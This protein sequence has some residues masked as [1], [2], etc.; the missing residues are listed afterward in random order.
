MASKTV[1]TLPV[2][3]LT[4]TSRP[5]SPFNSGAGLQQTITG[6]NAPGAPGGLFISLKG[7][8]GK[9][10]EPRQVDLGPL[11][12]GQGMVSPDG[13]YLFFTAGE[14]LKGDI[15]WVDASILKK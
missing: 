12:A 10:G 7:T 13:K 3:A 15:Y 2:S 9:W 5:T 14:R 1:P 4:D 11:A 8:D 6:R